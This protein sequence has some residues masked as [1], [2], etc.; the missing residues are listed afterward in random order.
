MIERR[1]ALFNALANQRGER[2]VPFSQKKAAGLRFRNRA[3]SPA[4]GF[5][6]SFLRDAEAADLFQGF[7]PD[8][9][10]PEESQ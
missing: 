9:P 5:P 8:E 3:G 1:A 4:A 2:V 6:E 10:V 7:L